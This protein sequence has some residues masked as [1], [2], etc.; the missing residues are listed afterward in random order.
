[1]THTGL[2]TEH[3]RSGFVLGRRRVRRRHRRAST[4]RSAAPPAALA[5][6]RPRPA[7]VRHG[8]RRRHAAVARVAGGDAAFVPG[9][10]YSRFGIDH[11]YGLG[12]ERYVMDDIT[13]IGHMGTGEAR[14]RSSATTPST[15]RRSP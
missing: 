7:D 5:V 15:G 1:M 12:I 8:A 2:I 3:V 6:D 4:R 11:G 10:D 9:E 13:V 14:R